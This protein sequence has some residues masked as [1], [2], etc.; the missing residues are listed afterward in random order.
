MTE[1]N[2]IILN[3]NNEHTSK[4]SKQTDYF[5]HYRYVIVWQIF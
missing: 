1:N 3:I 2:K 5:M 4:I